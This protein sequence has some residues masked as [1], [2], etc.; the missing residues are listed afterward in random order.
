MIVF[1]RYN[2][3]EEVPLELQEEARVSDLK[4][5]VGT[6]QGVR[7]ELLRVLFAGREL[8]STSTLQE[9]DLPE[10]ST[11]HVVLPP[12]DSSP[13]LPPS[14]PQTG[15]GASDEV[16]AAGS[17]SSF[18][19]FCKSCRSVQPGKLRVRCKTCRNTTLTLSRVRDSGG[20]LIML[21]QGPS[22]WDDVLLRGRIHGVCQS[23]GCQ[24][25]EAEFYMK[26][27]SHP[28]SDDDLSVAL[29][30]IMTNIRSRH[31]I[32]LP[33]FRGYCEVRLREGQFFLHAEVGYTLPCAELH[34][35]RILGEEQFGA[36]R[37][38]LLIGGLMCPS[39]GCGA[40]LVPPPGIKRLQCD[41]R[42]GCG[43]IFCRDCRGGAHEGACPP[44]QA[45]PTA[46]D[47]QQGPSMSPALA[48]LQQ[49]P[50]MSPALAPLQQGPSMSP[51]LAP[52]QQGPSMSPA[53]A[54]LQQGPSMSPALAPLQQGPSMSPALA[55]LQ[56]GPS[57]SPAL[58]PL[59]QGPSMS[60]L[61]KETTRPCPQCCAPV[62]RDALTGAGSAESPGTTI[63]W[64]TTADRAS[65]P[66]QSET[67]DQIQVSGGLE[68]SKRTRF[69]EVW[70]SPTDPGF[71][72]SGVLQQN[73]V[74]GGL[75]FSNRTR[76]Q[77]VWSFLKEPGF[78]RSGVLQQNQVSGGLEFSNR[79][80]FQEV[81]S[82]LK[83][84]GFRRS[85]VLQQNQVS[86]GLEFSNRTRFQEVW[87]FLKETGFRRSGVLQQNQVSG[88]LEFSNRTRMKRRTGLTGLQNPGLE[89]EMLGT[90]IQISGCS[91]SGRGAARWR[92]RRRKLQGVPPETRYQGLAEN[93]D[94]D[95]T[96]GTDKA[97]LNRNLLNHFRELAAA[98]QDSDQLISD[99]A[100]P[101]SSDR[102]GQTVLHE[103]S[104]AWSVDV[105]RF[106]L[107][108]G[109][110]L[111]H[112]D[113][114]GV[115]AL[116]VASA[117]DYEDMVQFLLEHKDLQTPLHF[118]SKNDSLSCI[119][120]L[121]RAG[122]SISAEDYKKRTPLQLA[123]CTERSAAAR[124]LLDFGAEAGLTDSDG[125]LCIT[126]MIGLMSPVA[127]LALSQFHVTDRMTRQQYFYLNLLEP[128]RSPETHLTGNQC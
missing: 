15:G 94:Q 81:W 19:V 49:G 78:R 6:Q 97:Q 80:R 125:Q 31:V 71:R 9:S 46:A 22:C 8:R 108:R 113:Q 70:S 51:A 33:C 100:D 26:C 102:F 119:K 43:F 61:L 121:L 64:G 127:Q 3:G 122:A 123:A 20:G 114:F 50:S 105:M 4:E 28:T 53:L 7:P 37:C 60:P 52:L 21:T 93:R 106:F 109:S 72:R 74:S 95:Q 27:A 120:A 111:H 44:T 54:P 104:R 45:P 36:E 66:D 57:M 29:D 101:N 91:R 24:G 117:L 116:H 124:L 77:E 41:P 25:N 48:P 23:D 103:I 126:A 38:L 32:C 55:P 92:Q 40:G 115:T 2:L 65:D 110:E 14:D 58:A 98:D 59:Q 18:F 16:P 89:L 63:A 42:L 56:Q 35:F 128:E 75:E 112:A 96:D 1:V 47:P 68:F 67:Q 39:A 86:G 87:S 10:Q 11:V 69:Q 73:Q 12:S 107:D 85:G 30:L 88:G 83:E 76:F 17:C 34:H 90:R 82:F 118:A 13:S 99:G 62:E 84:T 5:A 79:T